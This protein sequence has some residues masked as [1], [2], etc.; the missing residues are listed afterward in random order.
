MAARIGG[1]IGGARSDALEHLGLTSYEAKVFIALQKL[2]TRSARDISRIA[3]D[4]RSQVY[5]AAESLEERGIVEVQQ[6][7]LIRYRPVDLEAAK[8][9]LWSRFG[10]HQSD[11]LQ[12]IEYVEY[13]RSDTRNRQADTRT[14]KR[15]DRIEA[16]GAQEPVTSCV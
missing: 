12:Y 7:S 4:P 14:I 3:D 9:H 13:E 16:P 6:S 2:D 10:A 15:A 8:T 1:L 5:G 11:A